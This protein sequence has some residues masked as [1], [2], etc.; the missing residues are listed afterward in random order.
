MERAKLIGLV[1]LALLGMVIVLQ[2]TE[3]VET[4]ILFWSIT[5]PRAVLLFGTTMI[6][7]ALGTLAT[8]FLAKGGQAK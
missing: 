7:F 6:G 8:L 3:P 1:V 5:M 2:N 4:R